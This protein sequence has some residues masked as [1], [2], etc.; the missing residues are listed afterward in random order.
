MI[1][2]M[3]FPPVEDAQ[4]TPAVPGLPGSATMA[5]SAGRDP[6]A[7]AGRHVAERHNRQLAPAAPDEGA[8]ERAT[9]RSNYG[10]PAEP[11]V[12]TSPEA[13]ERAELR[14]LYGLPDA[15]AK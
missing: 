7:N 10:L 3:L 5:L 4:C 1:K 9:L 14:R 8:A 15:P 11:T 12:L 2:A 6:D 13:L